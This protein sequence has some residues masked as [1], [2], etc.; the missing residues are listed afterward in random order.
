MIRCMDGW[1]GGGWMDEWMGGCMDRRVDKWMEGGW[2][3]GVDGWRGGWME[4]DG[5]MGG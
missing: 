2:M 4:E 3:E 1:V 5:W